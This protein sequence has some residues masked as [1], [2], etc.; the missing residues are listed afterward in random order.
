MFSEG[1]PDYSG[2]R[3]LGAAMISGVIIFV[4]LAM[5]VTT[6]NKRIEA[7]ESKATVQAEPAPPP[8][9]VEEPARTNRKE[10]QPRRRAQPPDHGVRIWRLQ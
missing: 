7:L 3:V 9:A 10:A 6:L 1:T 8:A 4:V 5:A 2:R